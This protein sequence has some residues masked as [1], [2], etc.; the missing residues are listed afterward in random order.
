MPDRQASLIA[1]APPLPSKRTRFKRSD[2]EKFHKPNVQLTPTLRCVSKLRKGRN[3]PH[4][5]PSI[6]ENNPRD[7]LLT[8]SSVTK[9]LVF[10]STNIET[11]PI[12][13][14]NNSELPSKVGGETNDRHLELQEAADLDD[15][16]TL[17]TFNVD[18]H[19]PVDKILEEQSVSHLSLDCRIHSGSIIGSSSDTMVSPS[20][21]TI[22]KPSMCHEQN[23]VELKASPLVPQKRNYK[24]RQKEGKQ[25]QRLTRSSSSSIQDSIFSKKEK[26]SISDQTTSTG[27]SQSSVPLN[28]TN[29]PNNSFIAQANDESAETTGAASKQ[30]LTPPNNQK[31]ELL[32][33]RKC[34]SGSEEEISPPSTPTPLGFDTKTFY[35]NLKMPDLKP[36]TSVLDNKHC[37]R[38]E[39]ELPLYKPGMKFEKDLVPLSK[40]P[41]PQQTCDKL[42][43]S[44][45]KNECNLKPYSGRKLEVKSGEHESDVKGTPE[46]T[47]IEAMKFSRRF[48][49]R[50]C[51]TKFKIPLNTV[52]QWMKER[53]FQRKGLLNIRRSNQKRKLNGLNQSNAEPINSKPVV[54]KERKFAKKPPL[55]KPGEKVHS[56][57]SNQEIQALS[58]KSEEFL[59]IKQQDMEFEEWCNILEKC[60][61]CSEE[62]ESIVDDKDDHRREPKEIPSKVSITQFV[63]KDKV[64]EESK[65]PKLGKRQKKKRKRLNNKFHKHC[66][67]N[68]RDGI[69]AKNNIKHDIGPSELTKLSPKVKEKWHS[70]KP[71]SNTKPLEVFETNTEV[72]RED[73]YVKHIDPSVEPSVKI[74][75]DNTYQSDEPLLQEADAKDNVDHI[76]KPKR[77]RP[78]KKR[79]TDESMNATIEA[80]IQ[81][82]LQKEES[83]ID[84]KCEHDRDT[85]LINDA[86]NE[87]CKRIDLTNDSNSCKEIDLSDLPLSQVHKLRKELK[88]SIFLQKKKEQY[89]EIF[90]KKKMNGTLKL[91][92]RKTRIVTTKS[93]KKWEDYEMVSIK[94]QGELDSKLEKSNVKSKEESVPTKKIE[95]TVNTNQ[96]NTFQ[97]RPSSCNNKPSTERVD[98]KSGM[99]K[100]PVVT[101]EEQLNAK[102]SLDN[103]S[104]SHSYNYYDSDIARPS[105]HIVRP[106]RYLDFLR[107]DTDMTIMRLSH[108]GDKR[109]L[110]YDLDT[111]DWN[112]DHSANSQ[113]IYCYC[114]SSGS[115]FNKMVRCSRC[116]QWFHERCLAPRPFAMPI[117]SGDPFWL[118]VCSMCNIGS[119]CL[120]RMDLTWIDLVH[121]AIYDLSSKTNR[122]FH[123]FD[124]DL[125]PFILKNWAFFQLYK[126]FNCLNDS[127]KIMK[128]KETLSN[129]NNVFEQGVETGQEDG[130]WALRQFSP[131]QRPI[132]KVPDIGIIS[133]RTVLDEASVTSTIPSDPAL[134]LCEYN[135]FNI[136]YKD[137][138]KPI[139]PEKRKKIK[140]K[141][142]LT[143]KISIAKKTAVKNLTQVNSCPSQLISQKNIQKSLKSKSC[144]VKFKC[145]KLPEEFKELLTEKYETKVEEETVMKV[146]EKKPLPYEISKTLHERGYPKV[147]M[148][149][150]TILPPKKEAV[151]QAI[152][153]GQHK[154]KKKKGSKPKKT[155]EN[156]IPLENYVEQKV[157]YSEFYE[158]KLLDTLIPIKLDYYG[159]NNPFKLGSTEE[160][161]AARKLI[162]NR[163][164]RKEDL[165]KCRSKLR[166]RKHHLFIEESRK[167]WNRNESVVE[168]VS[169]RR[170]KKI[171]AEKSQDLQFAGKYTTPSGEMKFLLLNPENAENEEESQIP[172]SI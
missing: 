61:P 110:P 51:A 116:D 40:A 55:S 82:C 169:T 1:Q 125:M 154:P 15:E 88:R 24:R 172:D 34:D 146:E 66:E 149:F 22:S 41:P 164:L 92:A 21:L 134:F 148:K 18:I 141:I 131:P 19:N 171:I 158:S 54:S 145:L 151:V 97:T 59:E 167:L 153:A 139:L 48:G 44:L 155:F 17:A 49:L 42:S 157:S 62:D 100:P 170:Q 136:I 137:Y 25:C 32:S 36:C 120:K 71:L 109:T 12:S 83:L 50:K 47:I 121:L 27:A 159:E 87:Q 30:P 5:L 102:P 79:A 72:D 67:T 75:K 124:N 144:K 128:T 99:R 2:S 63:S 56:V 123:H 68:G 45:L 46:E 106:V 114:G 26:S 10:A 28:I 38:Q 16:P 3:A 143:S 77:G 133:E 4:P 122:K 132:Y 52:R 130:L 89:K 57:D 118:F 111:L 129:A 33:C 135:N 162:C 142:G 165:T 161:R 13:K 127:E 20:K 35:S 117:I 69:I 150:A 91:K 108:D 113:E 101:L 11:I 9:T 84:A 96:L 119:E 76:N 73:K 14:L 53:N 107:Q 94:V 156:R 126:H 64:E 160:Q 138:V 86:K 39:E 80:V 85:D 7:C 98:K 37:L 103:D 166:K 8:R 105:R 60:E 115:W 65:R 112:K 74:G 93:L 140:K 104:H 90:K 58:P 31:A 23:G 152:K 43:N 163:K 147:A 70:S 29:T 168:K 6:I 95:E 78:R 81:N